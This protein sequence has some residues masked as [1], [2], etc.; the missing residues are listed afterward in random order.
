MKWYQ[1]TWVIILFLIF[2]FPVGIGLMWMSNWK[3]PAKVIISILFGILLILSFTSKDD[4]KKEVSVN[5]SNSSSAKIEETLSGT[6][7]QIAEPQVTE[8]PKAEPVTEPPA[9]DQVLIDQDGLKIVLKEFSKGGFL[10]SPELKIYVENNSDKNYSISAD[11]LNI[12]G[13]TISALFYCK[14]NANSKANDSIT[15]LQSYL[16]DNGIKDITNIDVQF[17]GYNTD[18][19]DALNLP[20]VSIT[21]Q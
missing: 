3:T 19:Y 7:T 12:N 16:D 2:F 15:V 17:N 8:A 9:T 20:K 4:N 10:S 1:K 5:S 21:M 11:S 14:V 18:T 6:K 13:Y